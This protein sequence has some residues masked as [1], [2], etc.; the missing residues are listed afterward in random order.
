MNLSTVSPLGVPSF[1]GN[2]LPNGLFSSQAVLCI[3]E[4]FKKW[5]SDQADGFAEI[6]EY[7]TPIL[8]IVLKEL[9][10][11]ERQRE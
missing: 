11:K 5:R 4:V 8:E 6:G 7:P 10:R 9:A 2:D 1:S 3:G